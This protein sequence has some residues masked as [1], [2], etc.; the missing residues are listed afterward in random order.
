MEQVVFYSTFA[1]DYSPRMQLPMKSNCHYCRCTKLALDITAIAKRSLWEL[2]WDYTVIS[3]RAFDIGL[4]HKNHNITFYRAMRK[5]FNTWKKVSMHFFFLLF[6]CSFLCLERNKVRT[7]LRYKG[8]FT[9]RNW[10]RWR[11]MTSLFEKGAIEG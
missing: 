3:S 10:A 8:S 1:R 2:S 5:T 4:N 11:I 9:G 6:F 7:L